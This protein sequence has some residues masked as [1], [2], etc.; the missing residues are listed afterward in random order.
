MKD[1][2]ISKYVTCWHV[3][4]K[5]LENMYKDRKVNVYIDFTIESYLSKKYTYF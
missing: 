3:I 5:F 1:R 4:H 2:N